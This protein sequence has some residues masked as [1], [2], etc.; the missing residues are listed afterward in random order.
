MGPFSNVLYTNM[1]VTFRA[2]KP[3][4]CYKLNEKLSTNGLSVLAFKLNLNF[5]TR[6]SSKTRQSDFLGHFLR[7]KGYVFFKRFRKGCH[8]DIQRN[9]LRLTKFCA[10]QWVDGGVERCAQHNLHRTDFKFVDLFLRA[11][12]PFCQNNEHL[13]IKLT[14]TCENTLFVVSLTKLFSSGP[15]DSSETFLLGKLV[16]HHARSPVR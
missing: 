7:T 11:R 8:L 6:S 5:S 9:V 15:R 4:I 12:V 13:T 10:Q 2:C 14:V 3:K 16:G 1:G